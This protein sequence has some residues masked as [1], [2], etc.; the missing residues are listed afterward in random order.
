LP[1]THACRLKGPAAQTVEADLRFESVP[2][3]LLRRIEVRARPSLG[4]TAWHAVDAPAN[5]SFVA[6]R[7]RFP[8]KRAW[9]ACCNDAVMT[10]PQGDLEQDRKP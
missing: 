10:A 1:R 5:H 9:R 2:M 8:Y 3:T 7:G 4:Q 6:A